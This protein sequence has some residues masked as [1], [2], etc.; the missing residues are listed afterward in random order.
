MHTP[1]DRLRTYA[2]MKLAREFDARF[3]AMLLTGRISKWY[4]AIGNEGITVPA[5]LTLEAGDVLCSLHRDVGAILAFYL[6]PARAFPGFG[7]GA[8][9]GR[10]PE[11]EALFYRLACQV[12][13]KDEGF[14]RGIERSYHYGYFDD[15]SGIAHVGMIS[16]LGS[17]IP[18]ATG[19]AFAMK[20]D[21]GDRVAINFIGEGGTST[22]DFHEGMNLAAVWKLPL[23]LVIEN[24]RYAF[25]T[26]A[27]NQYAC[28]Q[29][30]DRGP[31]YGIPALTVNG[32]DPD[33]MAETLGRAV[34]R[35]RA[36]GGPTIVEAVVGRLR[37]HAEGDGSMKVVPEQELELYQAQDPVPVY[38]RRL[39]SEGVLDP[40]TLDRLHAR[41]SELVE[42]AI[43]RALAAAGPVPEVAFRPVFADP[44]ARVRPRRVA[45]V[46]PAEPVEDDTV[47]LPR[48]SAI[49]EGEA[50]EQPAAN[51]DAD[52]PTAMAAFT[53]GAV[54]PTRAGEVTYL[55]AIHQALREEMERD[56]SIV[57][58]GQDI[59]VFEGAFRVTKGLH[60]RWP[61]R[62]L[63]TPIS[64]S[65]TLG[66]AAGAA[67]FGYLPVVEMQFADF[68]S[69][70]FNQ[71][72]NVIAKLFYRFERP[73]PVIVR[74]PAG[75]GVGAGAFH[76]QNPEAWFAH[77]AGLKVLCPA[78][79]ADA[80]G[81]LKSALR[82]A[83]PVIF[84]ENKYLYR[85]VKEVLPAGDHL[86][87]IGKAQILRSGTDLTFIAYGA[88][89][90]IAMDAA[91]A[92]A[93]EGV[94]AEV[95]DLRSLVPYD[96]ETVLESVR[97]TNRAVVVHEAQ[98]TGGFGGEIAARL[99]DAAF[100]FLD[101]PVK[102]VAYPDRPS[103]YSRVLEQ[104]LFPDR[105]KLLAA[106]REVLAF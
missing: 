2:F 96:E 19:C 87:P 26:P 6:D 84:C 42:T 71:I 44:S 32:N 20:R 70:G 68:V 18:V 12:L 29:L 28:L 94:E 80:K 35:A 8:S 56:P 91:E 104:A 63:D 69:C 75:G 93:K 43:D 5:G 17:M 57:L 34:A 105:E 3:E 59:A 9:D 90:W 66:L 37:G 58:L 72:V 85:R 86:T 24:N 98:L 16:H 7:F 102:R 51:A 39:A 82:D 47:L 52:A 78:T 33:E 4:S 25:S 101:A 103:P 54:G 76:S 83:N 31:G 15:P 55:D 45:P 73:C 67:L 14:S 77:V 48:D 97:K 74:L 10:R 106:A 60:A 46:A 53:G 88:S 64:E 36:G 49:S 30:S 41:V 89:T 79:A 1:K 21:G 99:A 61:D 62:V 81:L 11:P 38:A 23:V 50:A 100:A 65:G 27:K 40:D 95:V 92:L 22:G 13:G